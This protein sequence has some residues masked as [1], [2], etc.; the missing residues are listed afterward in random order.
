MTGILA[1]AEIARMAKA[2]GYERADAMLCAIASG[3]SAIC[4][5]LVPVLVIYNMAV[6]WVSSHFNNIITIF[7]HYF[8]KIL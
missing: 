7:L 2:R 6:T 5:Y 1:G 8:I 3:F 4:V